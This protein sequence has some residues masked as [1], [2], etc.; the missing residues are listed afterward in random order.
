M[1]VTLKSSKWLPRIEQLV[2]L[3][4]LGTKSNVWH[5]DRACWCSADID[6]AR[7][8]V[9]SW[10]HA[11]AFEK[12]VLLTLIAG[13]ISA[14]VRKASTR[15]DDPLIRQSFDVVR[16]KLDPAC[17]LSASIIS[18]VGST[19]L[20][21]SYQGHLAGAV[22]RQPGAADPMPDLLLQELSHDPRGTVCAFDRTTPKQ[23][24]TR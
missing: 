5:R 9:V 15:R 18:R 10:H 14:D 19:S 1:E 13:M 3:R 22:L 16:T 12:Q 8:N 7:L 23:Q 17:P 24:L 20:F 2:R 21:F 6:N 4:G 11:D